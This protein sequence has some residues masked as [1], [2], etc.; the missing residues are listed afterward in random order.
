MIRYPFLYID[1]G[2]GSMLFSVAI[3]LA[4]TFYFLGKSLFLRIKTLI[5]GG[6]VRVSSDET[7]LVLYSEGSRYWN[8]FL[9]VLEALE[10]RGEKTSFLTS[11]KD[12]PV[13]SRQWEY[14]IPRYIGEGN[15]AYAKLN[16]LKARVVLMTTPGLDVYQIKRSKS[17]GHYSHLLHSVDDATSYRLFGIDY[18][19]SIL[20]SGEYQIKD[21]RDLEIKRHL[22]KRSLIVV[23]STY[24]DVLDS[25][26]RMLKDVGNKNF[27]VLVSPS[28]GSEGILARYGKDLLSALAKTGWK[29]IIRP[30]P[31]SRIS[32]K[33]L[34]ASLE[35]D[36]P[37]GDLV[38]WD[39]TDENLS[40]LNR[41]SVMISD[42]S[43]I[44]FDYAFLFNRPVLYLNADFDD[45]MYDSSDITEK[46]WKFRILNDI[47]I[48][49]RPQMFD[50]IKEVISTLAMDATLSKKRLDA[51]STAWHYRGESGNRVA[52]FLIQKSKELS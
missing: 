13:F 38:E 35:R 2:T 11:S 50:Q 23:G 21:L 52:D 44:I 42:F 32:E 19:D 51:G 4:A 20:L 37:H 6:S 10:H 5:G 15:R 3:G 46:P 49:L 27:T 47:G 1:P 41:A 8:V 33:E 30:H 7:A 31:Q 14:I 24:L 26:R 18:Y 25:K 34:L 40:S 28:W 16:F 36:Y 22:N 29:I 39:Y 48:E 43:G 45:Q 12:D 17:V 9:P